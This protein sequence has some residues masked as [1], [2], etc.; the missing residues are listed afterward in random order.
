M[1][2]IAGLLAPRDALGEDALERLAGSA[3]SQLAHR[4]PDG[5]GTWV[6]SEA[7]VALGHRR[8]A[9]IDTS[10]DGH[11]PMVSADGR[12]VLVF[13]GEVYDYR[14]LRQDLSGHG[15]RFRSQSDTE[16]LL[17]A[18][19][20]RGVAEALRS[21]D[22]MAA[23]AVWDRRDRTLWL[24]RDRFGEKPLYYGR[25]GQRMAFG[26]ELKA[27]R[28]LWDVDPT[29][30]RGALTSYVRFGYV[31]SPSTIYE[32]VSKV[33]AGG[34]VAI[35]GATGT[36]AP[37]QAWWSLYDVASASASQ[38][39]TG[40]D[41]DA[42]DELERVLA[43]SVRSRMVAD[44]PLG[45]FL[46]GGVDSTTVVALMQ[47]ASPR[48]VKTFTIGF[49]QESYDE[50]RHAR[51]VA[52]HLGTEHTELVLTPQDAQECLPS[53]SY[54]YDEPFADSSQIPTLLVA[55]LARRD[56][57][58]ALS[59]DGG[60]ELFAGYNRH[61]FQHGIGGRLLR[62]PRPMRAA[63]A[64]ALEV[65]AQAH[66][67]VLAAAVPAS[68]RPRH[69]DEKIDKAALWL[70]AR[71]GSDALRAVS[72]QWLAPE[73]V[74]L[75][76]SDALPRAAPSPVLD[77]R[78]AILHIDAATYLPDD[79]LTKVDRA[80]MAVGLEARVPFLA[81]HVAQFAWSLPASMRVRDGRGKWVVRRVLER[82][83]PRSLTERPK[84]GFAVPVGPWLRGD[85]RPWAESLLARARLERDGG[86][87]AGVVRGA[88][89]AHLRGRD[90][91]AQL[92]VI[93]MFQA[94]LDA[95][96]P[97]AAEAAA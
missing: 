43:A 66:P 55:Q 78:D 56:V 25:V 83:V 49:Q 6:D 60:D 24:A 71:D 34:V 96:T 85:L 58:V 81:P 10:P 11:Q 32:G 44:V 87:D 62:A 9:I 47:S 3:A 72:S 12:W 64:R 41:R 5:A 93:L 50:A 91:T 84:A 88:W 35:D 76:G 90:R 4:G 53:L 31:P 82:Y 22:A 63:A 20:R 39:F 23:M 74:V 29:I 77:Q 67:G 33:P 7:G 70:A 92:W 27:L 26:S 14:A 52:T 94:W 42:V 86:F 16:V 48:P 95:A 13:N 19:A 97:V 65:A 61:V 75:G 73:R 37:A 8:L 46:S 51:R 80:T 89:A 45:A 30:D 79:I 59:G 17:E 28:A 15:V 21:C 1:C 2:G 40:G 18:I 54:H 38:R 69:L 57:T 68:R 36:A